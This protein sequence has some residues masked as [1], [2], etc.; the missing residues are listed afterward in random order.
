MPLRPQAPMQR[1]Y[2]SRM[3]PP[4]YQGGY[5]Q[6]GFQG[7][8][9]FGQFHHPQ[10]MPGTM[11]SRNGGPSKGGGLLAKIL[12][13]GKQ[14]GGMSGAIGSMNRS[15]SSGGGGILNTLT[16]PDALNGLLNNTQTVIKTAQQLGP[17]IQQYGPLVR[18]LPSLWKLYKGLKDVS[19]EDDT[20]GTN[21]NG[22][23]VSES[24][25]ESS[26]DLEFI[27]INPITDKNSGRTSK[28]KKKPEPSEEFDSA[29][30]KNRGSV[31]KMYI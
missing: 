13:K 9:P 1:G 30:I 26:E 7:G 31:P 12:G 18:N 10:Q 19:T 6:G 4:R 2:G 14:Q 11:M 20:S 5:H 23:S 8:M 15:A 24:Q 3:M 21:E 22:S 28:N 27:A 17:V 25:L 16:N 29:Y